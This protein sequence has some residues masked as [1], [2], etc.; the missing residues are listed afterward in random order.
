MDPTALACPGCD[1]LYRIDPEAKD[2][3]AECPRCGTLLWREGRHSLES[4]LALVLT[5]LFLFLMAQALPLLTLRLHGTTQETTLLA[6]I[7]LLIHTG[8]PW[9]AA[10]LIV[11]VELA[12]TAY[13]C[14]LAFVLAQAAQGRASRRT[15]R[16]FRVVQEI[17]GWAMLEVFILGALVA[18]VK[19]T[20][21]AQVVPG[22]SLYSL[23]GCV[24]ILVW[25]VD[26]MDIPAIWQAAEEVP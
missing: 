7:G 8:W 24:L 18:Y 25:A 9:L 22:G 12:P 20:K 13:L 2:G 5:S 26:A 6:C 16:V 19:L 15:A 11:T 14:G 17:E 1:C 21:L 10:V 23:A 3:A 4:T